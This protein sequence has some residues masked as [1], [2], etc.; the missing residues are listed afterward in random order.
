MRNGPGRAR[1][2]VLRGLYTYA[3]E[4]GDAFEASNILE[5]G[6][7]DSESGLRAVTLQVI[8]AAITAGAVD[9][10]TLADL[11]ESTLTDSR[12][13]VGE[14]AAGVTATA[15]SHRAGDVTRLRDLLVGVVTD[16]TAAP[17]VRRAAV[18]ELVTVRDTL[19][20]DETYLETLSAAASADPATVRRAAVDGAGRL[21]VDGPTTNDLTHRQLTRLLWAGL[22]D[23][24]H[25]VRE[26]A[27]DWIATA[28]REGAFDGTVE[29][30]AGIERALAEGRFSGANR[31]ALAELLAETTRPV[32]PAF[33]R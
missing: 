8:E 31:T 28:R 27:A 21:L 18:D 10:G 24:T 32:A 4:G 17:P 19:D 23:R 1:L 13:A 15:I 22:D 9:D 3:S 11:L 29:N 33:E 25:G 14:R 5:L 16:E 12:S 6:L 7:D 26:T 2:S 30:V 20:V